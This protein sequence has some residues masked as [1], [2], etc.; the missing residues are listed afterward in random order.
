MFALTSGIGRRRPSGRSSEDAV[1]KPQQHSPAV[2]QSRNN[3]ATAGEMR[4]SIAAR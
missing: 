3:V 4:L 2:Q 1:T